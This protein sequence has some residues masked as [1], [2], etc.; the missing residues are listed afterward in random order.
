MREN[1]CFG[2]AG[3]CIARTACEPDANEP[4]RRSRSGRQSGETHGFDSIFYTKWH[5]TAPKITARHEQ[6]C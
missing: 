3:D 1:F 4:E 5:E 2:W 6:M